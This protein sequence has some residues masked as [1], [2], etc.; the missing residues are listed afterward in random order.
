MALTNTDINLVDYASL[1]LDDFDKDGDVLLMS[2]MFSQANQHKNQQALDKDVKWLD[3]YLLKGVGDQY[4][5]HS[6]ESKNTENKKLDINI[7]DAD[8]RKTNPRSGSS[9]H[10]TERDDDDIREKELKE[11]VKENPKEQD[12]THI[13][14]GIS[15]DAGIKEEELEEIAI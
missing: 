1:I 11:R 4:K 7:P 5:K 3:D 8:I 10:I 15:E 6:K 2:R 14:F 13:R 12:A 9:R